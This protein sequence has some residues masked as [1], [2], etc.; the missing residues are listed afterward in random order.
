MPL[1]LGASLSK[2]SIVTPGVVTDNLVMKHMYPAGAVQ[3]I[4]DGAAY[5]DVDVTDWID[6]GNTPR[7]RTANF[8]NSAWVYFTS[9]IMGTGAGI[10]T[11]IPG[12]ST[13][14]GFS[15]IKHSDDTIIARIGDGSNFDETISPNDAVANTWTH[16]AQTYDG[17]TQKLYIDGVLVD[18]D[19]YGTYVVSDDDFLIGAYYSSG[20]LPMDGYIC[21]VGYWSAALTEEQIKSIMWKQHADLTTGT[22][23]ESENLVSW[24]NLDTDANDSHGSNNGTLT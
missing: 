24:W 12:S 13:K 16:V 10:I 19:A 9:G 7:L 18:S 20:A 4:S 2:A 8:T 3:P 23:S 11:S 15:L 6:V 5:F 21:N 1:G 22:G 14:K 17:T